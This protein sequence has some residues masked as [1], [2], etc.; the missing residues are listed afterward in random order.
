M[1]Q[2]RI[3]V[4]Y[5]KAL[6]KLAQEMNLLEEVKND[7]ALVF[8]TCRNNIELLNF[9]SSPIVN[10]VQKSNALTEIFKP[11]SNELTIR[12]LQ[13]VAKNKREAYL[14][15]ISRNYLEFYKTAKGIISVTITTAVGL[16]EAMR[17]K[18]SNIIE[19]KYKSTVEFSE[20]VNPDI[21]GGVIM[22]INDTQFDSSVASKLVELERD[23]INTSFEE[24]FIY[25]TKTNYKKEE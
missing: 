16:D 22:R 21:I 10:S 17:K 9:L 11:H 14:I 23:L 19:T 25:T 6:F 4:R 8:E 7:V 1:R 12:F 18:I 20:K 5:A 13:L 24:R 2:T 15:D 3:P